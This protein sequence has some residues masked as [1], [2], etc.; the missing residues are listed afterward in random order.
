MRDKESFKHGSNSDFGGELGK[1]R[2]R[3]RLS[4]STLA[5]L[6]AVSEVTI[7]NW[8]SD[9][10]KPKPEHLKKLIEVLLQ[11]KAFTEGKELEEAK[12]FWE[13][14][15][16]KAVFDEEWFKQLMIG[17]LKL[18]V[19]DERAQE[20]RKPTIAAEKQ[21]EVL[22]I[23]RAG[24]L[25]SHKS[26]KDTVVLP[27]PP[28][29]TGLVGRQDE[30]RWLESRIMADKVVGISG[31]G[32]VGKTSLV[33]DTIRRT[34]DEFRGGI[35][36]VRANEITDALD[37]LRQLIEKFL[38]Y[39]RELLSRPGLKPS[40]LYDA[41]RDI[42]TMHRE[43]DNR[44]LIVLDNVEPALIQSEGLKQLCNIFR[45]VKASAIMTTRPRLP[46]QLVNE[47]LELKPFTNEV[48]TNLLIKLLE[49]TLG[50]FL[51]DAER[52][53]AI[54]ICEIVGNHAQA[55]VLIGAYF[56]DHDYES[57]AEYLQRLR[58][59]PQI[60]LELVERLQQVETSGGI[61]LTFASSY[62]RLAN[63]AQQLFVALGTPAGRGCGYRAAVALGAALKETED[64]T[65][66]NLA[67]LRRS[68]LILDTTYDI[69]GN[70]RINL[71]PLV[72]AFAR[73]L[74]RT[75][76]DISKET[77]NEVLALHYVEWAQKVDDEVLDADDANITAA[78]NWAKDHPSQ[79][80]KVTLAKLIYHLRWYWYNRFRFKEAFEWLKVGY[81]T[82]ERLETDYDEMRGELLFAAGTQYQQGGEIS[83]AEHCYQKSFD[84][85]DEVSK[86]V[87]FKAGL[88]E[89]LSGL[90][91]LEQQ[92]G[93]SEKA[94]EHY[95]R[96]LSIFH[97]VQDQRGEANALFR[98][99]FLALRTGDTDEAERYYTDS[100]NIHL[101]LGDRWGEGL[102]RYSLGDV[103]QQIGQVEKARALYE[104]GLAICKEVHNRRGE[105]A[106]LKSLGD[107]LLQTTGPA[108]AKARLTQSLDIFREIF[109]PQSQGVALYSLA[110]LLRQIGEIE[111]SRKLYTESLELRKRVNDE[112]GRGF[113]LK[114]LGDLIRRT[115]L[116]AHDMSTAKQHLEDGLNI[117]R[118]VKDR[119]NQGVALKALGDWHWQAGNMSNARESYEQSLPIRQDFHELRG[120]AITLKALGDL[121]LKGHDLATA[122]RHL[123][124]SYRFFLQLQDQRGQ[125][126]SLHSLAILAWEQN[127]RTTAHRQLNQS[128]NLLRVIQDRQSE[129]NVLYTLAL[130]AD[131]DSDFTNAEKLYRKSLEIA[132]QVQAANTISLSREG[133]GDFLI[134]RYNRKEK[135]E[136]I[137][138]LL[139]GA[140]EIYEFLGRGRHEDSH[141]IKEVQAGRRRGNDRDKFVRSL[142]YDLDE[143]PNG[144][145]FALSNERRTIR[146]L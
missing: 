35:A 84:I 99:G 1:M 128:L 54:M 76:P 52:R 134:R 119:R 88:G 113:V 67:V 11:K 38:P 89:A 8:E 46:A 86:K 51:N 77:L 129:G 137:G 94:Q 64:E 125:G 30:Q 6:A 103:C 126:V 108:E 28:A 105:G 80:A 32:G 22:D 135:K 61:R 97:N 116:H 18:P 73:E 127:D 106:V 3:I 118:K 5:S 110:F 136:E 104:E 55:I 21:D 71:H 29:L 43:G 27:F 31:M 74:L 87:D 121:A 133:L 142:I 66:E 58:E 120:Q 15:C 69:R 62:S 98:L 95:Q 2:T 111:Q 92:R 13:Q 130:C 82:M 12:K 26:P 85:F 65:R 122:Q 117:S 48:A 56:E 124:Q 40:L 44:V 34:Q 57:L 7:R 9:I 90:A 115:A 49:H 4:Q 68:K 33:A 96:S 59:R 132:T 70:P 139:A 141:R 63:P 47:G 72:Q 20:P 146:R 143:G 131:V 75:S 23:L 36:V 60:V 37:I 42:L 41:L 144:Q 101:K 16:L 93:E 78:L 81:D 102:A 19:D 114:G 39:E 109:D 140:A 45:S 53:D 50:R 112:R 79:E 24:I 25:S 17:Q 123:D 138:S 10:S 145:G 107:L 83:D 100:L 14:A 91:A